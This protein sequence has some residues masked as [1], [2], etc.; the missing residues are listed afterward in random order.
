[1]KGKVMKKSFYI[2]S[3]AIALSLSLVAFISGFAGHS[4]AATPSNSALSALPASDI[5]I[6]FDTQRLLTEA[7]PTILA[8]NPGLLAKINNKIEQF[9]KETGVDPH[10]F[11]SVAVGLRFSPPSTNDFDAVVIARGHF[12]S[13]DVITAGFAAADKKGEMQRSEEQYEGKTIFLV[14]E[15]HQIS[16]RTT[17]VTNSNGSASTEVQSGSNEPVI[18]AKVAPPTKVAVEGTVEN[19]SELAEAKSVRYPNNRTAI[20]A[21]DGNTI[22]IGDLKSVRAAIDAS[23]GREHVDDEL[24][25]MATLNSS[26]LIGFSGKIPASVTEKM[27]AR[28][29]GQEAKY[30]ASIREFYGSFSAVGTDAETFVAVR[31]ENSGQAHDIS[32]ALNAMKLLGGIGAGRPGNAEA[33]AVANLLKGLS[34]TSQDNEVQIKLNIKQT[35]LAPF[36]HQF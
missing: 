27:A 17:V 29:G 24:V 35:D 13:N 23:M 2:F 1:M 33:N 3:L 31:T 9:N 5:V 10:T 15:H 30:I 8:D 12:N 21:L 25:R 7:L 32:Q 36:V 26:A 22:A 4:A 28:H 16:A 20:V 19:S 18:I 6:M 11:D 34:I 14:N